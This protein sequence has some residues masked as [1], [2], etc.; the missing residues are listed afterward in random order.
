[1][2]SCLVDHFLWEIHEK[3]KQIFSLEKELKTHVERVDDRFVERNMEIDR[4]LAR[5]ERLE[6]KVGYIIQ[7]PEPS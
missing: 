6:T 2:I 5:I 7:Y 3:Q 1:M 4:L